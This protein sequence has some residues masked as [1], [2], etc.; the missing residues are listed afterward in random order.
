[1]AH[2]MLH[3]QAALTNSLR[4]NLISQRQNGFVNLDHQGRNKHQAQQVKIV[5]H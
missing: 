5:S 1:M 2:T 3:R 4:K